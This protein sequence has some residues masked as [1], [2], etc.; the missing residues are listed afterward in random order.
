[1]VDTLPF[2]CSNYLRRTKRKHKKYRE[3][4][5]REVYRINVGVRVARDGVSAKASLKGT[6]YSS[7][8]ILALT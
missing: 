8:K 6:S 7:T 5:S 4:H 2:A 3:K 1:M